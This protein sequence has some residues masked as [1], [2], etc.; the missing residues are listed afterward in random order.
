MACSKTPIG[1]CPFPVGHLLHLLIPSFLHTV[2]SGHDSSMAHR[3]CRSRRHY[4]CSCHSPY[5]HMVKFTRRTNLVGWSSFVFRLLV[6]F[7]VDVC[8]QTGLFFGYSF[9]YLIPPRSWYCFI[10]N[11][12]I[13]L[14]QS[15]LTGLCWINNEHPVLYPT[16]YVLTVLW[17]KPVPYVSLCPALKRRRSVVLYFPVW[18]ISH[19]TLIVGG[20]REGEAELPGCPPSGGGAKGAQFDRDRESICGV[21]CIQRR[22]DA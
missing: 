13:W 10:F 3:L 11:S 9:L 19:A 7:F 4:Y 15:R 12:S 16:M 5:L 21:S 14:V 8:L 22:R 20:I 18:S 6:S 1:K 2:S 17:F